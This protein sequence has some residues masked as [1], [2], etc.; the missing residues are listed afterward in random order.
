MYIVF[1]VFVHQVT[2]SVDGPNVPEL[3]VGE[4]SEGD[5]VKRENAESTLSEERDLQGVCVCVAHFTYKIMCVLC[6]Y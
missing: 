6:L 5:R 4:M 1:C 3:S 2:G